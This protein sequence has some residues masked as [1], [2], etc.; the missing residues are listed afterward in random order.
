M[1]F[2]YI[3]ND[4]DIIEIIN[5]HGDDMNM[6]IFINPITSPMFYKYILDNNFMN[7]KSLI[8]IQLNNNKSMDIIFNKYI[9]Y[10]IN[11]KYCLYC[12]KNI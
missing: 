12:N 1:D 8:I 3:E 10:N 7:K 6:T 2:K 11:K 4:I 5:K 9:K